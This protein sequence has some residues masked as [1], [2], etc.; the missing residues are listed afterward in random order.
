MFGVTAPPDRRTIAGIFDHPGDPARD[1]WTIRLVS[2][3]NGESR[4]LATFYPWVGDNAPGKLPVSEMYWT[5]D[6]RSFRFRGCTSPDDLMGALN[7]CPNWSL[8]VTTGE[9][10]RLAD[11]APIGS[12]HPDG[13]RVAFADGKTANEV[14]VMDD[15]DLGIE[16]LV[17]FP[18]EPVS[19]AVTPDGGWYYAAC[20]GYGL[21]I[22]SSAGSQDY[23]TGGY[24]VPCDM[25]VS[26]GGETALI[27][28]A[29]SATAWLLV[30]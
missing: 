23:L 13:R 28:D 9:R 26:P 29:E 17:T 15:S 30:R 8:D 25:A 12:I 3:S 4:D 24:G 10:R 18:S 19:G 6:S 22:S 11:D 21:V 2:V 14:W 5:P 20:P 1:A 16:L 27:L 7:R